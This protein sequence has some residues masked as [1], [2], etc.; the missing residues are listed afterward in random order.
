MDD[1][2][3]EE[4]A[5]RMARYRK[6]LAAKEPKLLGKIAQGRVIETARILSTVPGLK[7]GCAKSPEGPKVDT[8][9]PPRPACLPDPEE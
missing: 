6:R 8:T 7:L 1:E 5:A 9:Q 2:T 4:Y 3:P